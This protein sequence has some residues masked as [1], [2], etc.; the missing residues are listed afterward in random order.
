[1]RQGF[2]KAEKW[3]LG[4]C[5]SPWVRKIPWRG[6]WQPTPVFLPGKSH[7][8]RIKAGYSS[9]GC[10]ES[11]TIE[12]LSLSVTKYL[13]KKSVNWKMSVRF[14]LQI[15]DKSE[16]WTAYSGQDG[17]LELLGMS[18]ELASINGSPNLRGG[19]FHFFLVLCHL[20]N[21]FQTFLKSRNKF[22][23]TES[24]SLFPVSAR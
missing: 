18:E 11:D 22:A 20:I 10:K 15:M 2:Q 4:P 7:G 6:K 17:W 24:R 19:Y 9:W 16:I 1:M 21:C 8:Q 12:R 3:E 5:N 23:W 14:V 13:G